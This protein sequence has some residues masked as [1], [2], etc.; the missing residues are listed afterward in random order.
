MKKILTSVL[1]LVLVIGTAQA[2]TTEKGGRHHKGDRKEMALKGVNLTEAQKAQLKQ[3]HEA[4]QQEMK[5][6]KDNGSLSQ[7]QAKAQRKAIH[8]K[9]RAQMQ[10]ILTPEQK[11]Q[12]Q[13]MKQKGG[14][15]KGGF[16]GRRGEGGQ[17]FQDLNLSEDQ[18]GKMASL[19][20]SFQAKREEIR[21]NKSLTEE[22]KRE[23]YKALAQQQQE[24]FKAVLTP[25]QQ[26][27]MK[28]TRKDKR[29][30]RKAKNI[31]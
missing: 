7:D 25:E 18:K 24:Q 10:S 14:H 22:Q 6:V 13:Q 9:Y 15:R 8:E 12:M 28:E 11:T 1:A 17:A 29:M 20:T 27:K 16:E 3:L 26:Q 19:R 21:N 30:D 31:K 4:Q 23:Q 2:Q 5:A